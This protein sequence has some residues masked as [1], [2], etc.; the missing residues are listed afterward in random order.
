MGLQAITIV[1][2]ELTR[3]SNES[4]MLQATTRL[5]SELDLALANN[6]DLAERLTASEA[7]IAQ[8]QGALR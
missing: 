4:H 6:A 5:S 2:R 7:V 3:D 8:Q 1:G